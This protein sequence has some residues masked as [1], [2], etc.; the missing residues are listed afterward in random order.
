MNLKLSQMGLILLAI[1]AVFEVLFVFVLCLLLQQAE[2]EIKEEAQSKDVIAHAHNLAERITNAAIAIGAYG[3][4][5]SDLARR[6]FETSV[7]AMKNELKELTALLKD[8]AKQLK[9]LLELTK[10]VDFTLKQI[11]E[12]RRC[13]E[14]RP[15]LSLLAGDSGM[16]ENIEKL[17][18]QVGKIQKEIDELVSAEQSVARGLPA[19]RARSRRD[20]LLALAAGTVLN[21]AIA[22][23]LAGLFSRLITERQLILIDNTSRFAKALPLHAPLPGKDE[24][25]QLDKVFH[26]MVA[27]LENA[28]QF[29]KELIAVAS[30]E[31]RAPLTS[32]DAILAYLNAGGQGTLS[33][34]VSTRL[35]LAE[36]EVRRLIA[37]INDLLDVEKMEAGKFEMNFSNC[38]LDSILERS[39]AAV[40][41][42]ADKKD[43]FLELAGSSQTIWAD[44]ERLI[45]V[46]VNLLSNAIKFSPE[47][48]SIKVSAKSDSSGLELRVHDQGKGIPEKEQEKIFER[49]VQGEASESR[50]RGGT[51]LGLAV[52]KAIVLQHAGTIGVESEE[53]NGACFWFRIPG[54][55]PEQSQ[56]HS[57]G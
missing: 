46:L 1:P 5:R 39:S 16:S 34:G 17:S 53:G 22:I 38:S 13:I 55:N 43:I 12:A 21:I 32:I 49:F 6:S 4:S 7:A 42:A 27:E 51:G 56:V 37:L 50:S 30:H 9:R 57:E 36:G 14:S 18:L 8:D 29:K 40:R 23:F 10:T 54:I 20:I 25:A 45:Q 35:K 28:N 31:L 47:K 11:E 33:E 26:E 19:R 48:S 15:T 2:L 24:I 41:G 3:Y 52:C 44:E